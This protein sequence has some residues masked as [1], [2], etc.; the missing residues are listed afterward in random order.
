[1]PTQ[2]PPQV[3]SGPL[4]CRADHERNTVKITPAQFKYGIFLLLFN[5]GCASSTKIIHSRSILSSTNS[6]YMNGKSKIVGKVIDVNTREL[7]VGAPVR[8]ISST[9]G[10]QSDSGGTFNISELPPGTYDIVANYIGYEQAIASHIDIQA[11]HVIVL[12]FELVSVPIKV[13]Y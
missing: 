9:Y 12:N 1:V 2:F 13:L 11:D 6:L 8:V 3:S 4:G 7:I 10:A 5:L